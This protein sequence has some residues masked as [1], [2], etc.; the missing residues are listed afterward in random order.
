[1]SP[2]KDTRRFSTFDSPTHGQSKRNTTSAEDENFRLQKRLAQIRSR[3]RSMGAAPNGL[4]DK[5]Q[6][7]SIGGTAESAAISTADSSKK[8]S[9]GLPRSVTALTASAKAK[10]GI[11]PESPSRRPKSI[12]NPKTNPT[13]RSRLPTSANIA[14]STKNQSTRLATPSCYPPAKDISRSTCTTEHKKPKEDQVKLNNNLSTNTNTTDTDEDFT[15]FPPNPREDIIFDRSGE[16]E[17]A[18]LRRRM[19]MPP[20]FDA[21]TQ[22]KIQAEEEALK[23]DHKDDTANDNDNDNDNDENDNGNGNPLCQELNE[24]KSRL[25]RLEKFDIPSPM[26]SPKHVLRP[27]HSADGPL[28][29][30]V[31]P[32]S[33]NGPSK[34]Q[35]RP[36]SPASSIPIPSRTIKPRTNYLQKL[37]CA[38]LETYEQTASKQRSY[39]QISDAS[40][41]LPS[42]RL[43]EKMA[44]IVG[45]AVFVNQLLWAIIPPNSDVDPSLTAAL[46]KSSDDQVKLLTEALHI[47][48][49]T[50]YPS[51][52]PP[53]LRQSTMTRVRTFSFSDHEDRLSRPNSYSSYDASLP[54][55]IPSPVS[56]HQRPKQ[57][58][59]DDTADTYITKPTLIDPIID[60][61][62]Q[63]RYSNS[64]SNNTNTHSHNNNNN[65][66]RPHPV[67][68]IMDIIQQSRP[69]MQYTFD[70][71]TPFDTIEKCSYSQENDAA[72]LFPE[73]LGRRPQPERQLPAYVLNHRLSAQISSS[74]AS[75]YYQQRPEG[76]STIPL[77]S[78]YLTS[79]NYGS[80]HTSPRVA[81]ILSRFGVLEN[82][83]K[84]SSTR[85]I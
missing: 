68:G 15:Y 77:T 16:Q 34:A 48:T 31:S 27:M 46:E 70:Q 74:N 49:E 21:D 9:S 26:K 84:Q 64:N 66:N 30:V 28:S 22:L 32:R 18:F 55:S 53:A 1:M 57:Y 81:K 17:R 20:L 38:A 36:R 60:R 23:N 65:N 47:M 8:K 14:T 67:A 51:S 41:K 24:I 62:S 59:S 42:E 40:V 6:S 39:Q 52:S 2:V 35:T 44:S 79:T 78:S 63:N 19:S 50:T 33:T 13:P 11:T 72:A 58:Y 69:R 45:E 80:G 4:Q 12:A 61:P 71:Q 54:D 56:R 82:S 3:S 37:L 85:Y 7:S 5:L 43:A 83:P 29:P 73:V 75:N 10:Q 76:A 25:Q